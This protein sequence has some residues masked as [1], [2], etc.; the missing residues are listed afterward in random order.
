MLN[1]KMH[2][3]HNGRKSFLF[4]ILSASLVFGGCAFSSITGTGDLDPGSVVSEQEVTSEKKCASGSSI[5]ETVLQTAADGYQAGLAEAL[6]GTKKDKS[7]ESVAIEGSTAEAADTEALL[8]GGSDGSN[9]SDGSEGNI[10]SEGS[11]GS[12]ESKSSEGSDE[13]RS[14]EGS[15][16]NRSS[17]RSDRNRS[18]EG[19]DE[20]RSSEGSDENKS[21]NGSTANAVE[22]DSEGDGVGQDKTK[23]S[24]AA[25]ENADTTAA[26]TEG[27]SAGDTNGRDALFE[28]SSVTYY[29]LE[30]QT[31]EIYEVA[32]NAV[33]S[34]TGGDSGY[35]SSYQHKV[36]ELVNEERER[37]GIA[38]L[39]WD[40]GAERVAVIRAVEIIS[41]GSHTRPNGGPW[42]SVFGE[43]NIQPVPSGAGE[44]IAGGQVTPEEVMKGWLASPDHFE[45]IV[46][47]EFTGIAVACYY[48][49]NSTYKFYWV[50][51]FVT[52]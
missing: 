30:K 38:P 23:D 25:S 27:S 4:G 43:Y 45:N 28:D 52:R 48:D 14:S 51:T 31:D 41:A 9:G 3:F 44:N 40:V 2:I 16:E 42:Y 11:E 29:D 10:V 22:K 34:E 7:A 39:E 13:D 32:R 47:P 36:I 17:E 46:R 15:D 37:L 20:N 19:S 5:Y 1:R 8:T 18:S 21:S 12:S 49:P 24:V 26:V 50:Q 35:I 33:L 6:E